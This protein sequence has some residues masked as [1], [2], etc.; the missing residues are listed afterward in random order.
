MDPDVKLARDH[1]KVAKD[2]TAFDVATSI[3]LQW[4]DRSIDDAD[5]DGSNYE[6]RDPEDVAVFVEACA[7]VAAEWALLAAKLAVL[8]KAV[9]P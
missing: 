2:W 4:A 6:A 1:W 8:A 5:G 9:I 7:E 3:R